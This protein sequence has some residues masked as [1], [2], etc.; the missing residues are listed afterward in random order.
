MKRWF[1]VVAV[2][3]LLVAVPAAFACE[4]AD[5][6]SAGCPAGMKAGMEDARMMPPA[7]CAAMAAGWHGC[8]AL[9]PSQDPGHIWYRGP[10]PRRTLLDSAQTHWRRHHHGGRPCCGGPAA[11]HAKVQAERC[12]HGQI[13]RP[14]AASCG[15]RGDANAPA[16]RPRPGWKRMWGTGSRCCP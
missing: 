9:H 7:H 13:A 2:L 16:C 12:P 5:P 11:M 6:G 8:H 3:A 1:P 14:S 4:G 10:A 15:A